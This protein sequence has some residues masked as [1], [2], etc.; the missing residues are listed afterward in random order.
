MQGLN[1][2]QDIGAVQETW[3]ALIRSRFEGASL[4]KDTRALAVERELAALKA[5]LVLA[6]RLRNAA[7]FASC[8]LPAELL[9]LIFLHLRDNWLP[10]QQETPED[11][12]ELTLGWM[13]VLLTLRVS[14]IQPALS[15]RQAGRQPCNASSKFL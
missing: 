3:E 10:E 11:A 14:P 2:D 6:Q 7:V 4:E 5:G 15:T 1:R 9:S 13:T 8:A 12:W